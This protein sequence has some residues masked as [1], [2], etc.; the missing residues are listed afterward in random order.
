ML[1]SVNTE[2]IVEMWGVRHVTSNN[3][4]HF[5]ILLNNETH[6]CSCFDYC[7]RNY[8]SI[9]FQVML[10]TRAAVF[11]IQLIRSRWYNET[12]NDD[13]IQ[14]AFLVAQKFEVGESITTSWS[15][16]VPNL[17]A[18]I[19]GSVH[20][21]QDKNHKAIDKHKLYGEAWEKARAA[22]MVAVRKRDYNFITILDKYLK[23]CQEESSSDNTDSSNSENSVVSDEEVQK[24]NLDPKDL[25][26][27]CKRNFTETIKK[28]KILLLYINY[29][30]I[31]F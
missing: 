21:M 2:M 27:P 29:V 24:E 28:L 5:V 9:F 16:S 10:C 6:L 13:S 3:I 23:N 8:L 12:G 25:V 22:L 14:E 15:D 4:Q 20:D 11:H 17:S 30:F 19:Q 1:N 18:L 7:N 31:I 26:N